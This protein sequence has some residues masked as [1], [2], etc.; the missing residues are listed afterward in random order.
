MRADSGV[1]E[2]EVLGLHSR[3][4]RQEHLDRHITAK[5]REHKAFVCE[6][7]SKGFAR[8][9]ILR[10]H[11]QGHAKLHREQLDEAKPA[12][13]AAA[14]KK[15]ETKKRP[16]EV[17][18]E[19][20][21]SPNPQK[22]TRIA[23]ACDRCSKSK[24]V[25]PSYAA[26]VPPSCSEDPH[27]RISPPAC[28][29]RCDGEDPCARCVRAGVSCSF[30]RAWRQ[31]HSG[32]ASPESGSVSGSN[33]GEESMEG[34]SDGLNDDVPLR[35][36]V[37]EVQERSVGPSVRR[38]SPAEG[39][40]RAP[41]NGNF[42]GSPYSIPIRQQHIP[43][44]HAQHAQHLQHQQHQHQ[45][46]QHQQ[47][48][49]HLQ[50]RAHPLSNSALHQP[51]PS[52]L[53]Y[54]NRPPDASFGYQRF[55][56]HAGPSTP[57]P[58]MAP[59]QASYSSS[60]PSNVPH[61]LSQLT[62][63]LEAAAPRPLTPSLWDHPGRPSSST[64]PTF[65]NVDFI[66]LISSASVDAELDWGLIDSSYTP[67]GLGTGYNS[68]EGNSP[69]TLELDAILL[70]GL[71]GLDDIQPP[72]PS[73]APRP[74]TPS[75]TAQPPPTN[76]ILGPTSSLRFATTD[77]R[78][79]SDLA[80]ADSAA[81][82]L[83]QLASLT[84]HDSPEP[85][86]RPFSPSV[87]AIESPSHEETSRS[88]HL[89]HTPSD[90]WPLSYRPTVSHEEIFPRS[91]SSSGVPGFRSRLPSPQVETL[92][93]PTLVPRL[94]ESTR[95]R[96]LHGVRE[97][98]KGFVPFEQSQRF[99]PQLQLLDLFIQLFFERYQPLMPMI[100]MPT[101]DPNM[102]PSFLVLATASIGA[103]YAG[104]QVPGASIFAQALS[105]TSRRMCQVMVSPSVSFIASVLT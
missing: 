85:E 67:R 29:L 18:E 79:N 17:E 38:M 74:D 36:N 68:R 89:S 54:W 64:E 43:Q 104:D 71:A 88:S 70:N 42:S 77:P 86:S 59:S 81:E 99:V 11:E 8:R 37:T 48:Q 100:H 35:S 39:W 45:Q 61:P 98:S 13:A 73:P 82:C 87:D 63:M 27:S 90:P 40:N 25:P 101:F 91:G 20:P 51:M 80:V 22:A 56:P 62:S 31:M 16:L 97:I 34:G 52:P 5:H 33:D 94:K 26:R 10:R 15:R 53:P 58:T 65:G 66:D 105:E 44:Q 92:R 46:H 103:R 12:V 84:P 93:M 23:R 32:A 83:M 14:R 102:C 49:Q 30:E 9:D 21:S 1:Q 2:C 75:Y 6:T 60:M 4:T 57:P 3:Y 72:I 7:C 78:R 41:P 95:G 69:G 76:R 50:Q 24:Y 96:I 47:H 19:V 28:R 55:Q